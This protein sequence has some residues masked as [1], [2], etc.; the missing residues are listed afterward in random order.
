MPQPTILNLDELRVSRNVVIGGRT[1]V[2]KNMTV[3]QFLQAGD[4][5]RKLEEAD[6]ERARIPILVDL[7]AGHLDDTPREEILGLDLEQLLA[8]LAFIR[9]TEPAGRESRPGESRAGR[10]RSRRP[11]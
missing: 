5:E 1:R 4:V 6:S 3:E 7:I 9:G 10:Q 8:L 2:L 11:R